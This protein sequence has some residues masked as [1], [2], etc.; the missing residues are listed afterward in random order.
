MEKSIVTNT[1]RG[2]A[3]GLFGEE[4]FTLIYDLRWLV[5][6]SITL[7]IADFWYGMSEAR[8]KKE[9]VRWSKAWRRTANKVVDYI[10]L[11]MVAG[12]LGVAIGEPLGVGHVQV[13]A[14]VMLLCCISELNSIYGHICALHGMKQRLDLWKLLT[15]LVKAKSEAVGEAIEGAEIERKKPEVESSGV[16]AE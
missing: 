3:L 16:V 2:I 1:S 14:V 10:C 12:I 7:I 6:L 15:G 9:K 11:V 13:A 4:V 5:L 8:M